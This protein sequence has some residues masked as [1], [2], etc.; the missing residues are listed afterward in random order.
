[1][2]GLSTSASTAALSYRR[3]R[4]QLHTEVGDSR[5]LPAMLLSR[6]KLCAERRPPSHR[7]SRQL[8]LV[9]GERRVPST[10]SRSKFKPSLCLTSN[11]IVLGGRIVSVRKKA[12]L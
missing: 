6:Q 5:T 11:K 9:F 4:A 7:S 10:F 3:T 8:V 12:A 2:N 1:M